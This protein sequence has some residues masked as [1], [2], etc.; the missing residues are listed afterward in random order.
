[1]PADS[2]EEL[3][4]VEFPSDTDQEGAD[5]LDTADIGQDTDE[6][7][8]E[9]KTATSVPFFDWTSILM[10]THGIL[11]GCQTSRDSKVCLQTQRIFSQ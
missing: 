10:S 4:D 6:Q 9:L 5:E 2:D 1:M 7:A 8:D 11:H 3:S